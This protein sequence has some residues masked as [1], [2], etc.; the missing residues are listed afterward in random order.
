MNVILSI[1]NIK[2]LQYSVAGIWLVQL[3]VQTLAPSVCNR[4]YSKLFARKMT[5]KW[6]PKKRNF[7]K[8]L[9]EKFFKTAL[10]D[11]ARNKDVWMQLSG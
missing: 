1:E 2:K 5:W 9:F 10:S 6:S 7:L 4:I 8:T 11:L 3:N